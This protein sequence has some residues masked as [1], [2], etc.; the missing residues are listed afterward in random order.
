MSL[1]TLILSVVAVVSLSIFGAA[2][3]A[4]ARGG[5]GHGGGGGGGHGGGGG[6]HGGGMSG[7]ARGG[8]M[9]GGSHMGGGR[10]MGGGGYSGG[11][12]RL[13]GAPSHVGSAPRVST[14]SGLSAPRNLGG[15]N[16][17]APRIQTVPSHGG[18][19]GGLG[20]SSSTIITGKPGGGHS[21]HVGGA[22]GQTK[23]HT[24][25]ATNGNSNA[26][27]TGRSTPLGHHPN[28]NR[29]V[30]TKN[31]GGKNHDSLPGAVGTPGRGAAGHGTPGHVTTL[32][33]GRANVT[34]VSGAAR[35]GHHNANYWANNSYFFGNSSPFGQHC[36]F[37][38]HGHHGYH[39]GGYY[40]YGWGGGW[41]IGIG[42][43]YPYGVG[44]GWG[45]P[46]YGFNNYPWLRWNA[47]IP[48]YSYNSVSPWYGYN[49]TVMPFVNDPTV[50]AVP[51][52]GSLPPEAAPEEMPA[53]APADD[54]VTPSADGLDYAAIGEQ[55]FRAGEYAQAVKN[56]RHALVEDPGNGAC[57][58]LLAQALFQTGSFE[59]AAG[60]VQFATQVLPE[61][62]WNVVGEHRREL[63]GTNADYVKQLRALENAIRE[64][65]DS[66]S[67][68]F[69]LGWHYGF[70]GYP[71]E[72]VDQLD[73]VVALAPKDEI[74]PK[75]LDYMKKR[76]AADDR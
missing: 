7:G 61:D 21:V 59:E 16:H 47:G 51:E 50:V 67:L 76:A 70:N 75:V 74:A 65:K 42:I 64:K 23:S 72:A 6:G 48:C 31:L 41:G 22:K 34:N 36:Q 44:F 62:K 13:G 40:R 27:T 32:G 11:G 37:N 19:A 55:D 60:A 57:V 3:V 35:H 14:G 17:V 53:D 1:R 28:A 58:L 43:G 18:A 10:S 29:I 9:S 26:G 73:K 56:F 45:Y 46:Y 24:P 8:G 25:P 15:T 33:G 4:W 5:G 54:D 2:S 49:A 39:G 63:Y 38:N 30:D 68:R 12:V 71:K 66:P 20:G 69:L 52:D